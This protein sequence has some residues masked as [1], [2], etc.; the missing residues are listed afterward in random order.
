MQND[1]LK[2]LGTNF[3]EYAVAGKLADRLFDNL[4]GT[5][6]QERKNYIRNHSEEATYNQE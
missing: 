3:I 6:V 2:E 4:M 5:T 1:V